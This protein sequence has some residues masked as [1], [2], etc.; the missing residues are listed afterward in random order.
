MLRSFR[1]SPFILSIFSILFWKDLEIGLL[2]LIQVIFINKSIKNHTHPS[3]GRPYLFNLSRSTCI[4]WGGP[5]K[6]FT[7]AGGIRKSS[8]RK[9]RNA[10]KPKTLPTIEVSKFV[11]E[12]SSNKSIG[13]AI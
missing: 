3:K 8:K 11:T 1:F 4:P 12:P 6:V 2:L 9:E 10:L 7:Y 5:Q 13:Y